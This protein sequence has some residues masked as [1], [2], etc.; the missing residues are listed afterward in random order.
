MVFQNRVEA[1][2]LLAKQLRGY[3]GRNDVIVLGIPRGGVPVAF[4]VAMALKAP[5]DIFL[6]RKL[7]VPGQEELAFG[8]IASGDIRVLD[9]HLVEGLNISEQEIDQ[10]T[11]TV[12]TE[13]ERR[14]R[15]YRGNRSPLQVEG[16]TVL[17]IDDGIATGSSMRAAIRALRQMR[18]AR[19]VVAVPVAPFHTCKLLRSEADELI[20]IQEPEFFY[21]IGQFYDDFSQVTDEEVTELLRRAAQ[22]IGPPTAPVTPAATGTVEDASSESSPASDAPGMRSKVKE[23]I[24]MPS[25]PARGGRATAFAGAEEAKH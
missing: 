1:G 8:A 16:K 21:A 5:L 6:S 11:K 9:R 19:I 10:I 18:P 2:R 7:G 3:A 23:E 24:A 17:L 4:E 15:V 22:Q 14:E 25:I 20:C 12:E 13:L